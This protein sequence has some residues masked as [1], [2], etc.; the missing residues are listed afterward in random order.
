MSNSFPAWNLLLPW[1]KDTSPV[2]VVIVSVVVLIIYFVPY[3]IA[4][5]RGHLNKIPILVLNILLGW[6]LVGWVAALVW[7]LT[8]FTPQPNPP[9]PAVISIT[10]LVPKWKDLVSA[11]V[12]DENKA[13]LWRN[14][15]ICLPFGVIVLILRLIGPI[16]TTEWPDVAKYSFLTIVGL[17]TIGTFWLAVVSVIGIIGWSLIQIIPRITRPYATFS[18]H[19]CSSELEPPYGPEQSF[20]F[21]NCEQCNAVYFI[22]WK[23][24]ST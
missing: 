22:T 11:R 9:S 14:F 5:G 6:T 16:K 13:L 18:C 4:A 10:L 20:Q 23:P 15:I 17:S 7:S 19:R 3:Q 1:S 8:A 2:T 12:S 24:E 21:Y